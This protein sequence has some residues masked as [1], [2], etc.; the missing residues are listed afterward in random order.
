MKIFSL[1]S[2]GV[3]LIISGLS[4]H[5]W[6]QDIDIHPI[7]P[8]PGFEPLGGPGIGENIGP[9]KGIGI[10]QKI[11][12]SEIIINSK[13]YRISPDIK[14]KKIKDPRLLKDYILMNGSIVSFQLNNLGEIVD[15]KKIGQIHKFCWINSI[16]DE[17]IV[18]ND[19]YRKLSS[20]YTFKDIEG[21][22]IPKSA[23]NEGDRVGLLFDDN[24]QVLSIWKLNDFLLY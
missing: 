1:I 8:P 15:C 3:V 18:C 12:S 13:L 20:S 10:I 22:A 6:S 24:K 16:D 17:G 23:F 11:S 21:K 5:A 7:S 2:I 14:K 19:Q 9:K 4:W